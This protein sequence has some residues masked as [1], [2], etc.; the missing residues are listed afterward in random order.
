MCWRDSGVVGNREKEAA[1]LG[2]GTKTRIYF[3]ILV[4]ILAWK[5]CWFLSFVFVSALCEEATWHHYNYY[6]REEEKSS[7]QL[8]HKLLK[9]ELET[10]TLTINTDFAL[11]TNLRRWL[12][13]TFFKKNMIFKVLQIYLKKI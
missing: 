8:P 7:M 2:V 5:W 1:Q 9:N 13:L 4:I 3:S 11:H 6:Q 10:W 12:A